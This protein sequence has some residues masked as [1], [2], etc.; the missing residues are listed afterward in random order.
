MSWDKARGECHAND[1]DLVKIGDKIMNEFIWGK[2][3]LNDFLA[4]QQPK[5]EWEIW[6]DSVH[7]YNLKHFGSQLP[8]WKKLIDIC[9]LQE[10]C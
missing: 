2:T 10:S 9:Y 8:K 4:S 3:N 7:L 6:T 5:T 1:A